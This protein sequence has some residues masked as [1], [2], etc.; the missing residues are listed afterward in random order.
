MRIAH[1]A[2]VAYARSAGRVSDFASLVEAME[3]FAAAGQTTGTGCRCSA[4]TV[5]V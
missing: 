4:T 5:T 3:T 1:T 2:L